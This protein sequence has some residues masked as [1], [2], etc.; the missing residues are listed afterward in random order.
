MRSRHDPP[1]TIKATDDS[2]R[3]ENEDQGQES[4]LTRFYRLDH[5]WSFDGEDR[6]ISVAAYKLHLA[7]T[8]DSVTGGHPGSVPDEY[9]S[10]PGPGTA[11][12]VM[13][14]VTSGYWERVDGGYRIR[15]WDSIRVAMEHIE[16][17][18]H[19]AA[20]RE[21]ARTRAEQ[22]EVLRRYGLGD[23]RPDSSPASPEATPPG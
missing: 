9:L 20:L 14:L 19:R 21:Q 4:D 7:G 22:D 10:S 1:A 5:S 18:R 2:V 16:M 17:L 11:I 3:A 23:R 13:E 6:V 15:D 12:A 8:A